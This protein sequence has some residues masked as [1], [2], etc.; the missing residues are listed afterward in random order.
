MNSLL[1]AVRAVSDKR[2]P[3]SVR[4]EGRIATLTKARKYHHCAECQGCIPPRTYYYSVVVGGGGLCSLKFPDRVHTH[5]LD[6]HFEH[7]ERSRQF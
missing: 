4:R 5:C 1:T 6:K 3:V 2:L 7:M